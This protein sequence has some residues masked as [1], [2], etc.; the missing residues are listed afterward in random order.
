VENESIVVILA[1]FWYTFIIRSPKRDLL[2]VAIVHDWL[3]QIGGAESVLEA[4]VEIFPGAPVYTSMYWREAMPP[5]YQGWDI[6]TTWMDR[7]PGIY[8]HHQPYLLLY[9]L[10]FGGLELR[11][12]D[13]IIS[14]K[15]AFCL[16]VKVPPGTRHICYCLTPTRFLWDFETYVDREQVG[17]LARWLVRPF[18]SW[19]RRW[20]RAASERVT[21]FV[22]ISREI[23]ARIQRAYE[24][25]SVVLHPPVDTSRFAPIS[26]HQDGSYFLI[27]SRLIPYK[28][29][30]LAVQAFTNLGYPLWVAG[31]GRDR[32]SL[33]AM[34]GPN[35]RFLGYVPDKDLGQLLANCRAFVFPGLEDFGIAPVQAMAAGRPVVAFAGGGAL[36][37]V[38]EGVTGTFFHEQTPESLATAV[39]QFDHAALDPA[40][41]RSHVHQFDRTV[42]KERLQAI[43]GEGL[44][45]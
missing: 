44:N 26:T 25:D 8:C 7:L 34:A 17:R 9:P 15:S 35:I 41:I 23:R 22:A 28:R 29:I 13:L 5:A 11:G 1:A 12:Y 3:N 30:D 21:D 6:R 32:A 33:E 24:R 40:V 19:L 42:F 20:E 36:D 10:A 31:D 16:G 39:R 27:V 14:N 37:Y 43:V 2:R 38:V 45:T 18:L 4:L